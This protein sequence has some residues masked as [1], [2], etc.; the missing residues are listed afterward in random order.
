MDKISKNILITGINGFVGTNLTKQWQSTY[1]LYG[2]DVY[3]NNKQGVEQ[4]F[5]WDEF[6]KIPE[7]DTIIHLAGK[8]HDVNNKSS[9]DIY[10]EVNTNLTKK[11]FDYF[12]H[13]NAKQFIYFSSVKAVADT[14][15]GI[16]TEEA[17]PKP[18]T[19]YGQSKLKAEKY[20]LS[21]TIPA[22][23]KVYIL[24]P[25]MIHGPRNKGNLNLLYKFI[26]KRVPYP[27]G[28]YEN[29]RSFVSI[30]NLCFIIQKLI[31]KSPLTG[32][33]NIADDDTFSTKGL[34]K[35]IG[36]TINKPVRI[37][38]IPKG[39]INVLAFIGTILH[40]PFNKHRLNKL[41]ENYIVSNAKI[42]KELGVKL[43][44]SAK[45]GFIKTIKSF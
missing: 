34:V 24:R 7:V 32:I 33:Y 16:L 4:I 44:V 12:I 25:C 35:L 11:I 37:L 42:K 18:K 10:F 21:K 41:T 38:N 6:D 27:L 31:E 40:L 20:I 26:S 8:A 30:D 29:K 28:K 17:I 15:K 3:K 43:P 36:E 45:R 1:V 13:S 39:V 22:D 2:L 14:V 19:P 5:S 23:K 9:A